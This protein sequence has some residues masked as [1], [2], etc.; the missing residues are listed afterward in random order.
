[1]DHLS[2]SPVDSKDRDDDL[3]LR[4]KSVDDFIGQGQVL[5]NLRIFIAAARQRGEALDHT[6]LYGPP[7]LGKTTLAHIIANEMGTTVRAT[8]GPIIERKD[9]LAAILTDLKRGD[10]L[11]IDEIHR[12][13]RIVEECL[14]PALE[15]RRIDIMIGEGP[16]ARSIKLD[17]EPF[18]LVGATTRA[19]M[20][21]APLRSRFGITLRLNFYSPAEIASIL[22]RSASILRVAL[23][24]D[25]AEAIARR[26]RGTPR[27]AN[28]LLRRVRD[29]AQVRRLPAIDAETAQSALDLIEVDAVGLDAQDR[30]LLECLIQ[31]FAG[32]PVG[33][34]TLAV[35]L[36]EDEDTLIDM[37]EPYLIQL[38]FIART[39]R[40]RVAMAGAYEHLGLKPPAALSG[41]PVPDLFSDPLE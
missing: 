12:L 22:N 1:M 41:N 17:I 10:V 35:A 32:G 39:P 20:L 28:R 36:S 38:G 15:D 33:L 2:P 30:A 8:S 24:P 9:D 16:H 37:V 19:G 3:A 27:I 5:D 7:G 11:F 6:L 26:A 14:Y 34:N 13:N 4:P 18:T 23:R 21:T 31:R 40:G 29:I 25:G